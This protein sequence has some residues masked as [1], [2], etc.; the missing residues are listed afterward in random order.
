[1]PSLV[2][3]YDY[4]YI[5][6]VGLQRLFIVDAI[7]LSLGL[8]PLAPQQLEDIELCFE[9]ILKS[10]SVW[11]RQ[12]GIHNNNYGKKHSEEIRQKIREK[13]LARSTPSRLGMKHTDETKEKIRQ[14]ALGR[15]S[16]RKGVEPWNKGK[17]MPREYV[18]CECC[19]Q[20]FSKQTYA[21]WHG[22]NCKHGV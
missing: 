16:N 8:T 21:R 12:D 20:M 13:A 6:G 11:N 1:M 10:A 22:S 3:Y 2:P 7:S 19:K 9:E 5:Y 18:E 4:K 14:K 17:S 15:P